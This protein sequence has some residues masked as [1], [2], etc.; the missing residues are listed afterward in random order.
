MILLC[1]V[2]AIILAALAEDRFGRGGGHVRWA[3]LSNWFEDLRGRW[4]S[5]RLV[6]AMGTA[7]A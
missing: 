2:V 4:R 5:W 7:N 1:F 6:Q 3:V